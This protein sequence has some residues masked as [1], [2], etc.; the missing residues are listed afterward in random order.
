MSMDIHAKP[1]SKVVFKYPGN[2]R[3]SCKERAKK[4]LK[5][6]EVYTVRLTCVGNWHTDVYL[7]EIPNVAFNSVMFADHKPVKLFGFYNSDNPYPRCS[8]M[9]GA[10]AMV[11]SDAGDIVAT[12]FSSTESYAS[13]DIYKPGLFDDAIGEGNWEFEFVWIKDFKTHEGIQ[14]AIKAHH[15]KYAPKIPDFDSVSMAEQLEELISKVPTCEFYEHIHLK[16]LLERAAETA[17][18]LGAKLRGG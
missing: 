6:G 13:K 11:I 15:E 7:E 2:G 3:D 18:S 16:E 8:I 14:A 5:E 10:E 1:G 17:I 12:H 4:H 9:S